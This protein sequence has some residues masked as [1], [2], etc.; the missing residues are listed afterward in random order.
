MGAT[1]SIGIQTL[2]VIRQHPEEFTSYGMSVGRSNIEEARNMISEFSPSLVSVQ[3]KE[4]AEN[5][6]Q[7]IRSISHKFSMEKK[8]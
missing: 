5:S 3:L 4:D 7:G 6:A 1:G 2:D 8:D